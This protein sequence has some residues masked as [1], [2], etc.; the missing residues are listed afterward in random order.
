MQWVLYSRNF[1]VDFI[2]IFFPIALSSFSHRRGWLSTA[3]CA[4]N[5][6]IT[7]FAPS[8]RP[9]PYYFPLIFFVSFSCCQSIKSKHPATRHLSMIS[10][11]VELWQGTLS[12]D[13][14]PQ[15]HFHIHPLVSVLCSQV[16]VPLT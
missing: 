13:P 1:C 11:T 15:T 5:C 14:H 10:L 9:L 8:T 6:E 16:F 2:I 7:G 3:F 4:G 12:S